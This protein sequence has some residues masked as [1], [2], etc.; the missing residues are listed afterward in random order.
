MAPPGQTFWP[1]SLGLTL[2]HML[3]TPS[4]EIS[5]RRVIIF[6]FAQVVTLGSITL[7][8][9]GSY[10][11][12]GIT[13]CLPLIRS[14]PRQSLEISRMIFLCPWVLLSYAHE[15]AGTLLNAVTAICV[16]SYTYR[17]Y[18]VMGRRDP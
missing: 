17:T 1:L 7:Q 10:R 16:Y 12:L 9:E 4:S 18:P 11:F 14:A 8:Y 15:K 6:L 2:S 3:F 13:Q 5:F